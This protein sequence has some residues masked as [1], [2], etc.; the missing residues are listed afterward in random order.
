MILNIAPMPKPRM[1]RADAWK[2]RKC[3]TDYWAWKHRLIFLTKNCTIDFNQI[4]IIFNIEM[5]ASWSDKKK[6]AFEGKPHQSR[7][8]IDNLYKAIFDALC[9]EDKHIWR[10]AGEKLWTKKPNIQL[11][12]LSDAIKSRYANIVNSN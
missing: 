1:T 7:P 11:L 12:T 8:D 2:K 4:Y 3:V 5:P 6:A 10:L 9:S